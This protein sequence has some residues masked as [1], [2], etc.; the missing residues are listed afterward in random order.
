MVN[1]DA[2]EGKMILAKDALHRGFSNLRDK[3]N[4]GVHEFFHLIDKEDGVIDGD[5]NSLNDKAYCLPWLD[6]IK[7]VIE[8]IRSN[9]T[10]IYLYGATNQKEFLAV[11]G[12]Y[13]FERPHL[14][15]SRHPES[16][17]LLSKVFNQDPSIILDR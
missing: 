3:K 16:Y 4:V 12:E 15:K 5:P 8:L 10:N 7:R 17:D 6:F 14:L 11:T 2:M 1:S 9:K 13:F